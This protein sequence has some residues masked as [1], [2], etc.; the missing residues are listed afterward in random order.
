M[1]RRT[2]LKGASRVSITDRKESRLLSTPKA[3]YFNR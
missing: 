3:E 2:H 1:A